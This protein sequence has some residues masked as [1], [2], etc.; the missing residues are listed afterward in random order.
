[1]FS[2]FKTRGFSLKSSQMKKQDH[3]DCFLLGGF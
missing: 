1:M 2:D 3:L